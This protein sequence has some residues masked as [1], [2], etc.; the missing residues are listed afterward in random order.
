MNIQDS[1]RM[2]IAA[3][4]RAQ[5]MYKA[6]SKSF[7]N[8][9]TVQFYTELVQLE[10]NHEQKM[11]SAFTE[12][13][14]G[15]TLVLPEEPTQELQG[16]NLNDPQDVLEYAISRE[17]LAENIY[18]S[19]AETCPEPELKQLFLRFA[20]EEDEH[21]NLL[22]TEIQRLQ[23]AHIWFDPSELTGLMED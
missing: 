5:K 2:V 14:P 17:E 7:A 6:L 9:E 20:H 15:Q 4:I 1:Y 23:G 21:K 22:L 18:K 10:N 8:P 11:R 13:F 3:E 19:L 12:Q 16:V